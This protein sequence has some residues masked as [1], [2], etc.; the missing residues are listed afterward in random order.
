[1]KMKCECGLKMI[2]DVSRCA[3]YCLC[4]RCASAYDIATGEHTWR[5]RA[6][7]KNT[8]KFLKLWLGG[9]ITSTIPPKRIRSRGR[10]WYTDEDRNA[11]FVRWTYLDAFLFCWAPKLIALWAVRRRVP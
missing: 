1:M 7:W 3:A 2:P 11:P 5:G 6:E 8:V 10:H 9:I 4:G